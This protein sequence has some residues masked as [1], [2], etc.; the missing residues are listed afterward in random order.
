[1]NKIVLGFV[2]LCVLL[3]YTSCESHKE[4]KEEEVTFL[5]TSPIKMDFVLYKN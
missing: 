2:S 5:V 4:E 1:M 3:F